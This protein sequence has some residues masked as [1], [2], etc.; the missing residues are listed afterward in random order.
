MTQKSV[1]AGTLRRRRSVRG[2]QLRTVVRGGGTVLRIRALEKL[3]RGEEGVL[4]RKRT[5]WSG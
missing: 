5:P 3:V 1:K 4:N 2:V